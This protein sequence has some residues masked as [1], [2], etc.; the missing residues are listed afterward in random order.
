MSADAKVWQDEDDNWH[1]IHDPA[2]EGK[3]TETAYELIDLLREVEACYGHKIRWLLHV[4]PDGKAG[5]RGYG[6]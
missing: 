2:C 5:L 1:A 6:Y 3:H 4:Y